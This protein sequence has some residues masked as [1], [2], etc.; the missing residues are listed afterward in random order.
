MSR[1]VA[2]LR[3]QLPQ[4]SDADRTA[5]HHVDPHLVS[6]QQRRSQQGHG[7]RDLDLDGSQNATPLYDSVAHITEDHAAIRQT[8]M[9]CTEARQPQSGDYGRMQ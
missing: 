9:L 3:K 8:N 5:I 4:R 7:V 6:R 2:G 1:C